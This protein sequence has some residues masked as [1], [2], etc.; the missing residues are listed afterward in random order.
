M[1]GLLSG[2]ILRSGGSQTFIRLQDAQPQ[3]PPT[4]TT[5]TGYTLQTSDLLV[6]QYRSSLGNLEMSE[7]TIYSNIFNGNITLAGTGTGVVVVTGGALATSTNTGALVVQGGISSTQDIVVNSILFGQGFQ[8]YN[9]ISVTGLSVDTEIETNDGQLNLIFG[10]SALEGIETAYKNISIGRFALSSGTYLSNNIAIGDSALKALGT[11]QA[12][13]IGNITGI[14]QSATT[15]I[16][17][18]GHGVSTGTE[19]IITG[20]TDG[21]IE[22]NN[23]NYWVD[24]V[25]ADHLALYVDNILFEPLDTSGL[26][27]YV[28]GGVAGDPLIFNRNIAIGIDSGSNLID[29]EQNL[30]VGSNVAD[31]LT[32]GSYNIFLG[33]EVGNNMI[34]GT[35]NIS[36]GGDNL[37]DGVDNQ[38]NIGSVLYYDGG[39][40]LYVNSD[41]VVGLGTN[42]TSSTTGALTV[43]G[44]VGILDD[45]YV[46]GTIY[47]TVVGT[48]IVETEVN[49]ATNAKNVKINPIATSATYYL[50]V[51]DQ[52]STNY[53]LIGAEQKLNYITRPYSTLTNYFNTGNNMLNVPGSIFS[54]E[55][56]GTEGNLLYTPRV[57]VGTATVVTS[58]TPRVGDFWIDIE[59]N[60]EYQYI[61]DDGQRFWLQIAII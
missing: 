60:A 2:S 23:I 30:F 41:Q 38:V 9:N 52:T 1:P 35:G 22:L 46:G 39:G 21:P 26:P 14:T 8:G 50:T 49:T 16:E 13:P 47:G 37:I 34:R 11:L 43:I 10:L 58:I 12:W 44:G 53:A 40:N 57:L 6:T 54:N 17:V 4:P 32:T 55:G 15:V 48:Q 18:V 45:L 27:P 51:A 42:S 61:D 28:S 29:G 3:L 31:N 25:D 33:H 5:S 19:L 56:N 7:G 59:T 24:V 36:I 20:L